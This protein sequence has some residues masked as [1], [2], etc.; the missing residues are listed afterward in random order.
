MKRAIVAGVVALLLAACTSTVV[1][2]TETASGETTLEVT[3]AGPA[4]AISIEDLRKI[5]MNERDR[6]CDARR[7]THGI[8]SGIKDGVSLVKGVMSLVPSH[9]YTWRGPC[10]EKS[11]E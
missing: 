8:V 9:S 4:S 6:I 5:A 1:K 3:T 11:G 2:E 7:D 10:E